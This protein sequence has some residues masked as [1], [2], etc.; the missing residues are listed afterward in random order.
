MNLAVLNTKLEIIA[1]IDS[2]T[3]LIWADR[4]N[5]YGDFELYLPVT[6]DT[7]KVFR[8]GY[9][10]QRVDS[11]RAM[12]IE[13]TESTYDSED[14]DYISVKGRSLE[15][16]LDRRI[17]WGQKTYDSYLEYAIQRMLNECIISPEDPDRQI[18]NFIFEASGDPKIE[19]LKINT[20][21]TGKNLYEA[22]VDICADR[23]LGFQVTLNSQNQFVFK[24]IRGIDRSYSQNM[25]PWV[26]FSPE[27]DNLLNSK[28]TEVSSDYRNVALV[29]GE[30]QG[31]TRKYITVGSGKGMMR[32]EL[33]VDARDLQSNDGEDS[34]PL[35]DAEINAIMVQRGN[36]NL[37]EHTNVS[38]FEGEAETATSY[39]FGVDFNIGDLVQVSNGRGQDD[40]VRVTEVVI[41]EDESG[42]YIRPTFEKTSDDFFV[43]ENILDS[44]EEEIFDSDGNP[45]QSRMTWE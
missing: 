5:G 41:N 31:N 9:Y 16:I 25:N 13:D 2:Y 38:T 8:R 29:M 44:D 34:P 3:S 24:L 22:I 30:D 19:R 15:S 14:G 39:I 21:Y 4:Y 36:E 20:Q 11:N 1:F 6:A 33:L 7:A 26:R 43:T 23:N 35:S 17:I 18:P 37:A 12:I 10:V 42:L 28:Y 45:I 40:Q 27:F 32:R